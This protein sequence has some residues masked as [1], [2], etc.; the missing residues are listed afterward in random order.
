MKGDIRDNKILDQV[1]ISEKRNNTPIESVIHLAGLKSIKESF[2]SPLEYWDVNVYGSI[3]LLKTM[4]MHEC[5]QIVF[6]SRLLYM[7]LMRRA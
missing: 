3:N 5:F 6:S 2:S 4:R 1:F 7:D